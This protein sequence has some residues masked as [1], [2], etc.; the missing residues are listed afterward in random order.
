M[1]QYEGI[2]CITGSELIRDDRNPEGLMSLS[3]V[4]QQVLRGQLNRLRRASQG[5]PA[6]YEYASL[7]LKYR[8]A[9]EE[10]HGDPTKRPI[11]AKLIDFIHFDDKAR[12]YLSLIHI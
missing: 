11:K 7:P 1:E 3:C 9:W 10:Q 5:S 8:R 4:K 6:L 12:E 2:L